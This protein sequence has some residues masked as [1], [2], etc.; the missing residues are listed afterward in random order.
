MASNKRGQASLELLLIFAVA[1]V[2][3]LVIILLSSGQLGNISA[4]KGQNDALNSVAD[5]SAAAKD[6]YSQGEGAKKQVYIFIP[7][8]YEPD[9]SFI[10]NRSLLL[11]VED[12]DYASSEMFDVHGSWPS[13]PGGHWVW[14]IS[15]GNKVRIGTAMLHLSKN[16]VSIIME[17]NSSASPSF[18][19][20][21]IWDRDISVQGTLSWPH[22][23]VSLTPSTT[24]FQLTP[25]QRQDISLLVASN[26]QA[27]G[28]YAGE[29]VFTATEGNNSESVRLPIS[30]EVIGYRADEIPP[31]NVTPDLWA[32]NLDPTDSSTATFTV[33]TNKYTAPTDVTFTPS[34]GEPGSWVNDTGSLGPMSEGTCRLKSMTITVPANASDGVYRGTIDVVGEGVAGASDSISL[35]IVVGNGDDTIDGGRGNDILYGESG[36]DKIYG[37]EE[38]DYLSGGQGTDQLDG[39][40]DNDSLYGG[41]QDDLMYGGPGND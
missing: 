14:V 26:S 1:L 5:V 29:M 8:G 40:D 38:N 10:S 6:V 15:E 16:A 32:E 9:D 39:G 34:G 12:T 7:S 36:Y 13:T 30:V 2:I 33:C 27:V 21:S 3:L 24:S 35:F 28:F 20:E 18:F 25:G 37:K 4:L 22:T 23:N 41:D 19:V 11:S 17:R 31:L